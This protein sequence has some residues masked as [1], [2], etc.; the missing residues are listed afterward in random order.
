MQQSFFIVISQRAATITDKYKGRTKQPPRNNQIFMLL[1]AGCNDDH[2]V[3][4]ND[5][6]VGYAKYTG[7]GVNV[8]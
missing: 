1:F 8:A 4:H 6:K 3:P 7:K 5:Q 2:I